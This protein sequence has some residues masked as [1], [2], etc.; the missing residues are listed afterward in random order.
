MLYT[1]INFI[2]ATFFFLSH[3]YD[4]NGRCITA[5]LF[6]AKQQKKMTEERNIL[7]NCFIRMPL[8]SHAIQLVSVW[9]NNWTK[10]KEAVLDNCVLHVYLTH[11]QCKIFYFRKTIHNCEYCLCCEYITMNK[12]N[13]MNV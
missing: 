8:T 11:Q 7:N 12:I 5:S 2:L 6:C 13:G 10:K 4:W 1:D 9:K 3:Q